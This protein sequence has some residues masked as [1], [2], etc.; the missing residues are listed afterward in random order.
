MPQI[1]ELCI[2][3]SD[4]NGKGKPQKKELVEMH[5]D[6]FATNVEKELSMFSFLSTNTKSRCLVLG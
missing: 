3:V 6:E 2:I 1:W 4:K 5:L